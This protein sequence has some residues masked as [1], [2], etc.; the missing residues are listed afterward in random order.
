MLQRQLCH[1]FNI[2]FCAK[3]DL[4]YVLEITF[5]IYTS[6][7][8]LLAAAT[9]KYEELE[10]LY[11]NLGKVIYEGLSNYAKYVFVQYF[12]YNHILNLFD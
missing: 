11:T 6:L 4:L 2:I 3:I 12:T 5:D 8:C 1:I 9:N 10:F 7:P